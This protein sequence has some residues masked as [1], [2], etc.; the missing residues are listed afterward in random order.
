MTE[1]NKNI[2]TEKSPGAVDQAK[3]ESV[4]KADAAVK[5]MSDFTSPEV[6]YQELITSVRK[7]HP[8]TDISMIQ[9]AYEVARE[10]HKDQ[11][12]KSG[13][14]YII[15]PLCVGIIL[16]DLE[17]DKETIVAGLLHDAVEDTWMTYEEVE[18]EFGSEVA[19]LVDGVTKL[20]QLNYSKDKVELPGRKFKKNVSCHG[21]GYQSNSDQACG[22]SPQYAYSAVHASGKAAGKGQGDH[23]Y[24]CAHCHA[25]WYI[26]DQRWNWMIF[27][28]NT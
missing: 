23:G 19:L 21:K 9:K 26:E 15:H 1:R 25:P 27:R 13:E 16:A 18:K 5:S 3:I 11:K 10:A 17:L 22:P 7:Y 8:S 4:K 2:Q 20:G 14:P 6:L 24:L 12:R 28:L